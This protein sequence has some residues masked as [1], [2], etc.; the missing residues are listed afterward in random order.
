M[1]HD[2]AEIAASGATFRLF[3]EVAFAEP[4]ATVPVFPKP[5]TYQHPSYGEIALTPERLANFVANFQ[6]AIYQK[7]IPIDAEHESKLSG[8]LGYLT[9][10]VTNEDGSVDAA[11]EWTDRGSRLVSADRYKYV[12]PEWYDAWQQPD[13]DAEFSDVLVGLALTTRPFFKDS[14]LRPLVAR[15]GELI[16]SPAQEGESMPDPEPTPTNP[17]PADAPP[18]PPEPVVDDPTPQEAAPMDDEPITEPQTPEVTPTPAATTEPTV[19]L[20]EQTVQAF[21]EMRRK[22]EASEKRQAELESALSVERREKRLKA[23]TDEVRGRNDQND[24]PWIAGPAGLEGKVQMLMDMAEKFGE[25]SSHVRQ[26]IEENRAAAAQ[27]KQSNLFKELGTSR[28]SEGTT[29][30]D[31]VASMAT[32]RSRSSGKTFEQEFAAVLDSNASLRGEVARERRQERT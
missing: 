22:L 18:T 24:V 16:A 32:E 20:N 19:A 12:S 14:A 3:T 17:P 29:A 10:L 23:F 4:P 5:G 9:G 6:N 2:L 13:T 8:A 28:G 1:S 31:R 30:Y 21:G 26:Y 27:Q 25:A 15:E 11:V 7:H